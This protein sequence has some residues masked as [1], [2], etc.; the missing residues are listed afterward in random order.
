MPA[1]QPE[2][3]ADTEDR[4]SILDNSRVTTHN[5]PALARYHMLLAVL[6]AG[7]KVEPPVYVRSDW[8]LKRKDGKVFHF[9]L[10]RDSIRMTTLL[11]VPD[12]EAA[13]RLIGDNAWALVSLPKICRASS[14]ASTEWI[15]LA[16]RAAR[17][18]A[19]LLRA[20]PWKRTAAASGPKAWKAAEP[21]S[22]SHCPQSSK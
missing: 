7:W 9:V 21:R 2:P 18:W 17:G 8:S 11:S 16:A 20:M 3:A 13:R 4:W 10:R 15:G 6:D 22:T 19:W 5:V 14:S 1:W 12:C